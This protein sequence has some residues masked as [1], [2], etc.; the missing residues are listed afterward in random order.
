[1]F[2]VCR[3]WP[4]TSLYTVGCNK[5]SLALC[6]YANKTHYLFFIKGYAI[7][8]IYNSM[9]TKHALRNKKSILIKWQSCTTFTTIF[10]PICPYS[11]PS[12]GNINLLSASADLLFW[13]FYLLSHKYVHF[14]SFTKY[15]VFDIHS[16]CSTHQCFFRDESYT[17]IRVCHSLVKK[18]I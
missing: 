11:H 12:P 16:C 1:M 3:I 10:V 9:K 8:C 6:A 4:A 2:L 14:A 17:N 18:P 5:I 7:F 15:H 13:T